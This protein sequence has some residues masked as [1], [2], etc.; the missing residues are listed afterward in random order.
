MNMP[1]EMFL[2]MQL[3]H[4]TC[5]KDRVQSPTR[6]EGWDLFQRTSDDSSVRRFI[7]I[8]IHE[9]EPEAPKVRNTMANERASEEYKNHDMT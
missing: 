5:K 8:N 3:V 6:K 1:Y 7:P 4:L 9:Y 2:T